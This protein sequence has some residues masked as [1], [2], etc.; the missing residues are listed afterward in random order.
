MKKSGFIAT[1]LIYSF[2]LVF[3]VIIAAILNNFIADKTIT[4]KYNDE[5]KDSLNNKRF[6]L[7][8]Y[9]TNANVQEGFT[10]SN[11]ISDGEFKDIQNYWTKVGNAT[12]SQTSLMGN[13]TLL[14][15]STNSTRSYVTQTINLISG[16]KYYF[17]IKHYQ[18]FTNPVLKTYINNNYVSI[19]TCN[20][21]TNSCNY[22]SW[23]RSSKIYSSTMNSNA[24]F[25]VG[26]TTSTYSNSS[27]FTEAMVINLTAT[28]G[29][30]NEPTA[31]WLDDNVEYFE[32]TLNYTFIDKIKKDD[33]A[34]IRFSPYNNFRTYHISCNKT[35]D[36]NMKM[37]KEDGRDYGILE[38]KSI[39][40]DIICNVDWSK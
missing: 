14:K 7:T 22:S 40:D 18:N 28:F 9:A 34:T 1:S 35:I 26:D 5:I 20:S 4:E 30:G 33:Y 21:S 8:I 32:G 23:V 31:T 29:E 15:R 10:L 25:V 38:F 6:S 13:A 17:S 3:I 24:N 11:L 27:Y 12:F 36:Y 16:N 39:N 19:D 37:E 2:F